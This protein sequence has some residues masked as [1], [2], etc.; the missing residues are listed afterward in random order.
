LVESRIARRYARALFEQARDQKVLDRV[1]EDLKS[2]KKIY[3]ESSDFRMMLASPIIHTSEKK[4]VFEQL[5]KTKVH[6]LTYDFLILLLDKNRE[7]WL[8]SIIDYFMRLSD[9]AR[10][11]I[12]AQLITAQKLAKDQLNALKKQLDNFSG[13]NV[14]VEQQVDESLLG[15]FVV[16][17][18]DT[19]IDTSLRNQL[20][21]L[22]DS[23]VSVE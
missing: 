2:I 21:K 11:I 12:R 20:A 18:D 22:R 3:D 10:G 15:G 17:L 1:S 19:V 4:G 8:P 14:V 23:M 16:H 6:T 5:F 9:E 7:E 13:K